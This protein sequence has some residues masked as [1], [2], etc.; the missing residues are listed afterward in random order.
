MATVAVRPQPLPVGPQ[1]FDPVASFKTTAQA[2]PAFSMHGRTIY[3]N[4]ETSYFEVYGEAALGGDLAKEMETTKSSAP[5]WSMRR[6][7]PT[8]M[9]KQQR[10]G[11]GAYSVNGV[12]SQAHPT[13]NTPASWG[14]GSS[15]RDNANGRIMMPRTP[16]PQQYQKVQEGTHGPATWERSP[17]YSM[18]GKFIGKED[19]EY[20]QSR[21]PRPSCHD[22]D[23][24]HDHLNLSKKNAPKW[25]MRTKSPSRIDA[26]SPGPGAYD[27][28]TTVSKEHPTKNTPPAWKFGS[29]HRDN[30]AGRIMI[31]RTPSPNQY[32]SREDGTMGRVNHEK[33][34]SY[35][36]RAK[37]QDLTDPEYRQPRSPRPSPHSHEV[38]S[39]HLNKTKSN[40]AP[41]WTMHGRSASP[42]PSTRKTNS[43][44]SPGPGSY[45]I[46]STVG[47]SCSPSS[48]WM[49]A[50]G[51]WHFGSSKRFGNPKPDDR[52]HCY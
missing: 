1:E 23:V 30:V 50:G 15:H 11:P 3:G 48:R 19:A 5:K 39:E 9:D 24:N 25:S 16:S 22:H 37:P 27:A 42:P 51:G 34:P 33:S 40:A 2:P 29:S 44:A 36:M 20:R 46:Q 38:R 47:R 6:R 26:I 35:S 10:P 8:P 32:Q 28:Q 45:S 13:L 4:W 21:S 49:K 52:I 41:K 17:S 12:I 7:S 18:R 31:P 14:F 43:Y